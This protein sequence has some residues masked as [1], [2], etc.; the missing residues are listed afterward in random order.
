LT[1]GIKINTKISQVGNSLGIIIPSLA[2]NSLKLEKSTPMSIELHPD[3][4]I[5]RKETEENG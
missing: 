1:E 2:C 3:K 4:I 5:I